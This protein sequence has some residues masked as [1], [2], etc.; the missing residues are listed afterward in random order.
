VTA[1]NVLPGAVKNRSE[2]MS[3]AAT[4][5]D[6][7]PV[8]DLAVPLARAEARLDGTLPAGARYSRALAGLRQRLVE[9]RLQVAVLGQF[10]RGKSSFLNAL[11]G[12][13]VLPT[14][15]VPLTAIA[16]FIHWAAAP[17]VRV[18]YLDGRPDGELRAADTDRLR[19]QLARF[20]TEE[21]NPHNR[22]GVARVDLL[23]PAPMLRH[24]IV[25]IDTPGVG[26]TLRHNSDAAVAVLPECD[27][28]FFVLSADPPVTEAE[29]AY[30]E[31]VRPHLARLFFIFNKID[32]LTAEER[33]VAL[34]FLRRSLREHMPA[35]ADAPIF[36]LSARQ[37]LAARQA[38]DS[39]D[40]A[41]SG[42]AEIEHHLVTFLAREKLGSLRQ[43]VA[44]KAGAVLD[45]A[46]MDLALAIRALEMPVEEL[47][48]RAGE[49]AVAFEATE[50]QRLVAR[51]LLAGDRRRAV[52]RLEGQA[53]ALR[54][55]ARGVLRAVLDA[56]LGDAPEQAEV[57][58]KD[59][60][61]AAIP[62]FFEPKLVE[63]SRD[64][65]A[66][67]D[68]LLKGHVERAAALIAM[69][70]TTAAALF[71]IPPV[72]FDETESFAIRREP[73]W[74]TERWS[75]GLNSLGGGLVDRLLPSASRTS[76]LANRLASEIGELVD[77]NVE[78]LRWATLQNL[79]TAFQRF[80]AGFDE[81]LAETIEATRGAIEAAAS[82]RRAHA[83]GAR[84]ELLRLRQEA[85]ALRELRD[86]LG[87]PER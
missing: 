65:A 14:G 42:L 51:D 8:D 7:T 81:R 31:Q 55:E 48:R 37:G 82:K 27:A 60:I 12:V 80:A 41:E 2:P 43:A 49:F 44:A 36:S 29:I 86:S 67:V 13:P 35:V 38:G 64:F 83:D 28:G 87:Q 50:R 39:A 23:Y 54:H 53:A 66:I 59:A 22:L 25:L 1:T 26:S 11:L 85:A 18:S 72:L 5:S 20:V 63:M 77:R 47:E 70:R 79:D 17:A 46:L 78:N 6:R 4:S 56:T 34:A 45:V 40:L 75:D 76:R 58:A 84:G 16:T 19:E 57:A 15:V 21:E 10:K 32:Y 73:Y 24:G 61:A 69:V 3:S 52:E 9:E 68:D 33:D 62:E 30:L 74:V 71:E